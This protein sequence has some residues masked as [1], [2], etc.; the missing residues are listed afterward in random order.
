MSPR[1]DASGSAPTLVPTLDVETLRGMLERHEPVTILD[2]RPQLER[3]EWS[4]PGSIHRD[5]YAALRA[6]DPSALSNLTVPAD[7]PVVTVCAAGRTSQLAAAQLRQRGVEAFSL[8]GGM[9]AWSLA[10]NEAEA[11]TADATL[12]QFRRTGKG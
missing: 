7:Q 8:A 9:K 4:I 12:I 2:I 3:D 1:H 6:G 5:A 10:W 11:V